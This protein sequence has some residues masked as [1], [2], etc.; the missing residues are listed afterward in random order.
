MSAAITTDPEVCQGAPCVRGLRIPVSLVLRYLAAG[1]SAEELV[2]DFPELTLE[3]V[4]A[5][6][7][8]GKVSP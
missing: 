6:V 7:E 5:C 8:F 3:D 2:E 1:G 4:R